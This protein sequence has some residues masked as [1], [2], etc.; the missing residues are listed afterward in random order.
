TQDGKHI[1]LY[2]YDANS[3]ILREI[4]RLREIAF[5]AVEEGTGRRRDLDNL[6]TWYTQLILW[7]ADDLEIAGAY[8]LGD[9]NAIVAE[10]GLD[11][12][13]SHSLFE[14]HQQRMAPFIAQGL[15]LG[16]SFVQPKYWGKRSLDYLWQG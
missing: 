11:G 12:L 5:R 3:P 8:R 4:A 16:R 6:D 10:R 9:A 15:E 14:Y 13:Y 2:R 1:Y 7:D